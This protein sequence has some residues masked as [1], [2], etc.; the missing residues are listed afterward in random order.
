[1]ADRKN[2]YTTLLYKSGLKQI[3]AA[4]MLGVTSSVLSDW[5][6]DRTQLP[7]HQQDKLVEIVAAVLDLVEYFEGK[8]GIRP[9]LRN[10]AMLK[11]A[12]ERRRTRLSTLRDVPCT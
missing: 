3:A 2:E 7:P 9:D 11:T 12:L 6:F 10:A 1:M 4:E 5:I 8:Y